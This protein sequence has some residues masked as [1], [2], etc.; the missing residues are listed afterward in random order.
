M[1]RCDFWF[2]GGFLLLALIIFWP[3]S[4]NASGGVPVAI[5]EIYSNSVAGESEWIELFNQSDVDVFLDDYSLCDNTC[6]TDEDDIPLIGYKIS[7][8][9]ILVIDKSFFKFSLNN[10]G[11]IVILK[12]N[13][14]IINSIAYGNFNDGNIADNPAAPSSGKSLARFVEA[15]SIIYRVILPSRGEENMKKPYTKNIKINEILPDPIGT[16]SENEFI[17]LKLEDIADLNM[18]G[19]QLCAKSGCFN[20]AKDDIVL[21]D[22]YKTIYATVSHLVLNNDGSEVGL[23]DP[24]GDLVSSMTYDKAPEG[25]SYSLVGKDW[26]W[27]EPSPNKINQEVAQK[28][29]PIP[30]ISI[31]DTTKDII[32]SRSE[33]NETTVTV[34]GIVTAGANT[35]SEKYFYLQDDQSAIQVYSFYGF[36]KEVVRGEKIKVTGI[37]SSNQGERRIKISSENDIQLLGQ[38]EPIIP[39]L[40]KIQNIGEKQEGRYVKITG[41]IKSKNGNTV[42]ISDNTGEIRV[43]IKVEIPNIKLKKNQIVE[44][45]G[46]VSQYKNNYRILPF[47]AK[48]VKIVYS[49]ELPKAGPEVAIYLIISAL[50][51]T[52]WNILLKIVRKHLIWAKVSPIN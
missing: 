12:Q 31:P 50:I 19:W 43:V 28:N 48:D 26:L 15:Q 22:S 4:A 5:N 18:D 10:D 44:I 2:A 46:I 7:A 32:E 8:N 3:K 37:L 14:Q 47:E 17:E 49:P 30:T 27:L 1:K 20:F 29:D 6:K 41:K 39:E 52:L 35:L 13:H 23:F 40:I 42:I 45:S 24:N 21:A 36:K 38:S 16:D 9:G 25:K 11:D 34:T 33:T 51:F